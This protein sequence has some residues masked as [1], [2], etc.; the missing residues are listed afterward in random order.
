MFEHTAR[1]QG[2]W[3]GWLKNG[4]SLEITWPRTSVGVRLGYHG[5]DIGASR[6]LWIGF[7]FV[8]AFIPLGT[9]PDEWGRGDEPDWGFDLSREFGIVLH[10]RF[11]RKSWNWPFHRITLGWDYETE[12]GW[13]DVRSSHTDA[14]GNWARRPNAKAETHPYLYTLRSGK[15]QGRNATIIRQRWVKGR[16]ILSRLGLFKRTSYAIDVQ[17]DGEVGERAGSW[18][19]G[20]IGCGYDMLPGETPLQTLR[21][22]ERERKFN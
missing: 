11:W 7:G 18:K 9:T 3:R 10:W 15:V 2:M 12:D 1:E 21:R 22:M 14:D 6:H 8:Q 4:Q 17:F 13:A 19:G 20:T 16:H 5:N